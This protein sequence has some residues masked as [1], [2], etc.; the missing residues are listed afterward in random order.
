VGLFF[1]YDNEL[2]PWRNNG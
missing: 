1:L 2:I